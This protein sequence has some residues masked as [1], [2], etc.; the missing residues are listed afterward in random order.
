MRW[1]QV[2]SVMHGYVYVNIDDSWEGKRDSKGNIQTN[3]K[4]LDMK[5][6]AAYVHSKCLKLGIYSSPGPKTC[7]NYEGSYG[8]EQQDPRPMRN[9]ASITLS[10][11]SAASPR[12]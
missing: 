4:F 6:L 2:A 12:S 8:H 1:S 3:E 11:T 9:G 5:A 7:A 10:M